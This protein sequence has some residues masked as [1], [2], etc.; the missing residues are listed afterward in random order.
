MLFRL[1]TGELTELA[2]RVEPRRKVEITG[3]LLYYFAPTYFLRRGSTRRLR[4]LLRAFHGLKIVLRETFSLAARSQ[5]FN[6][7]AGEA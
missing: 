5:G 7:P 3:K 6:G 4:K 2:F 1:E